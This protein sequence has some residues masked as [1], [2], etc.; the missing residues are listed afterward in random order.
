MQTKKVR[1]VTI[2]DMKSLKPV[3]QRTFKVLVPDYR[4]KISICD[5]EIKFDIF[6][7]KGRECSKNLR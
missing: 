1:R 6:N 7:I 2:F 5:G 4:F 3:K